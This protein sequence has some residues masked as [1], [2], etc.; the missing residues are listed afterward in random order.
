MG[1]E[2]NGPRCGLRELPRAAAGALSFGSV[3]RFDFEQRCVP[4]S[5]P[6]ALSCENAYEPGVR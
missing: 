1:A 2:L 4:V 6:R 3:A 5:G